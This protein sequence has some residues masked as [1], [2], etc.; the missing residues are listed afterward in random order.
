MTK[1]WFFNKASL[2]TLSTCDEESVSG[3]TFSISL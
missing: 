1:D 3:K 2:D